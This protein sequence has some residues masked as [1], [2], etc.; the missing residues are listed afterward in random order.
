MCYNYP[1][2]TVYLTGGAKNGK[3]GLGQKLARAIAKR[4]GLSLYYVATM[5][6][7]DEEDRARIARHVRD[8]SGLGFTTLEQGRDL[9]KLARPDGFYLLDSV[10]AL[11][12]NVMFGDGGFDPGAPEKAAADLL[13][14][15]DRA[16]GAVLISDYIGGEVR[17]AYYC[18][19]GKRIPLTGLSVSGKLSEVLAGIRFSAETAVYG[20]CLGPVKARTESMKIF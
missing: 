3:S 7:H 4:E 2:T 14:F 18:L 13:A 1:M 19:D 17:L 6:P 8:R 11:L 15:L 12:A 10:T 9:A 16:G 20:G 5:I